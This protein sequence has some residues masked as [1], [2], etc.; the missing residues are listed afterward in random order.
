MSS[1]H[2]KKMNISLG[3][4][5]LPLNLFS[6]ENGVLTPVKVIPQ[7]H[8]IDDFEDESFDGRDFSY[9]SFTYRIAAIRNLGRIFSAKQQSSML[10]GPAV[11]RLD[12]HLVNWR[13]HLPESKRACISKDGQLDEM[14]FQAHMITAAL[15][16]FLIVQDLEL[17]M[18]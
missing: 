14:L 5:D 7:A 13:L 16:Y 15:V 9:S 10:D 18:K 8:S 1:C 4:A 2:A 12:A 6:L 11:H 3:Y 17:T